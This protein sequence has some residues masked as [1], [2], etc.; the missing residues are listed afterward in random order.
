MVLQANLVQ[1]LQCQG[2]QIAGWF[3]A[4][5]EFL[6]FCPYLVIDDRLRQL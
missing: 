5:V 6:P 3:S 1:Y 2:V 4:R